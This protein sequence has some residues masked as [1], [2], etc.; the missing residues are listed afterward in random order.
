MGGAYFHMTL[1]PNIAAVPA[2]DV[3]PEAW[4]STRVSGWEVDKEG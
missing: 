1:D 3:Q 2:V 4:C